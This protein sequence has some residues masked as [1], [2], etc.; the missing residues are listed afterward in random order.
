MRTKRSASFRRPASR[1]WPSAPTAQVKKQ[2]FL[3]NIDEAVAGR[4]LRRTVSR[5][6]QAGRLASDAGNQPQA[7]I[8]C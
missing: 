6:P 3:P 4:F 1:S 5:L 7:T 8:I 2:A